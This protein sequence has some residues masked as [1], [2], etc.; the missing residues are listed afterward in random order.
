MNHMTLI[1]IKTLIKN[2]QQIYTLNV[3]FRLI[4]SGST[5]LRPNREK[6]REQKFFV[7]TN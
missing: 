7:T 6:I 2:I 4:G 3:N 1:I 5:G